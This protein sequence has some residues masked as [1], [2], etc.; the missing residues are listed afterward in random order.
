MEVSVI[1]PTYRR[2]QEL[3]RA[4][5][6][7]AGQDFEDFEV[8]IIDDNGDDGW[9][10][11]VRKI[12]L[13][14]A[15][16][17]PSLNI[18]L[19]CNRPNLGSAGARNAGIAVAQGTY[20]TFLDDDDEYLP[21]KIRNQFDFMEQAQLDYSITDLDLYFDN[22]R[23][24]EHRRRTYIRDLDAKSL[25]KYH[26]MYHLSGTDTMMFT[27]TYLEQIGC[28]DSVDV[29][30]EYYLMQKA[31]E[32]GGRFG[33]LDRCDVK[34]YVHTGQGGLSSGASKIS[35]ENLLYAHKKQYFHTLSPRNIRYIRMRHYSVLAFAHLR[36]KDYGK[37]LCAGVRAVL[38]SPFQCARMLLDLKSGHGGPG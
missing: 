1:L 24:S 13:D 10:R 20:V 26:L 15:E 35:G 19:I 2:E 27:R 37:F 9:N 11:R 16:Q 34:A 28:F 23:L 7:L 30:D 3:L 25:L 4:L 17:F 8:V 18:R 32:G 29:G 38:S 21:C 14:A 6:S 33:Y 31:I 36:M 12:V 5:R 22:G